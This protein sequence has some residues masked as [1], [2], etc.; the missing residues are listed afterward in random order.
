[1]IGEHGEN[2]I[3]VVGVPRSGTTLV[4]RVLASHSKIAATAEPWVMLHPLYALHEFGHTA[5]YDAGLAHAA[6]R[7][8]WVSLPE[9]RKT[10]I[11]AIQRMAAMLYNG[12]TPPD[13]AFFMD[14]TPRYYNILTELAEVFPHAK[15]VVV[16][17]NP[18]GVLSSVLD[19]WVRGNWPALWSNQRDLLAGPGLMDRGIRSLNRPIIF[20]YEN[21]AAQPEKEFSGLCD[22]LEIDY[23]PD[24]L[25][26]GAHARPYGGMGDSMGIPRFSRP[27][28]NSV[29]KWIP[30]LAEPH[31]R[32]LATRYLNYLSPNVLSRL[33]YSKDKLWAELH[34]LPSH[35]VG[36]DPWKTQM[37]QFF[38]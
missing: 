31:A 37:D 32:D 17:R 7:D 26:Y 18:L 36:E 33:G 19:S 3:F 11:K 29:T 6:L 5:E 23:E 27:V 13:K 21:F 8:F 30:S 22:L 2:L 38:K 34:S 12:A 35:V 15:F 20:R 16:L 1:V 10:Y 28:A 4:Q 24:M 9:G 14:K 25:N